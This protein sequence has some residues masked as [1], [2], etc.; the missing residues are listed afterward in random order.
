VGLAD[1]QFSW[2]PQAVQCGGQFSC[3][4]EGRQALGLNGVY[5]QE[6]I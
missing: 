6:E 1:L 5:T 2:Q 3:R 4:G